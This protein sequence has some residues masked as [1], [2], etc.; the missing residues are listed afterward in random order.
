MRAGQGTAV[1]SRGE[2]EATKGRGNTRF[3]LPQRTRAF[4]TLGTRPEHSAV[5]LGV[6]L[7]RKTP[8]SGKRIEENNSDNNNIITASIGGIGKPT[9]VCVCV[10][11]FKSPR[12][13]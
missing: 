7:A 8:S 10:V 12:N 13:E 11:T 3:R 4:D 6:P 1:G 9:C 2:R 5:T